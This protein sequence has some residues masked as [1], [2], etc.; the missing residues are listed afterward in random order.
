MCVRGM[1]ACVRVWLACACAWNVFVHIW[2]MCVRVGN[3]CMRVC[4]DVCV[5]VDAEFAGQRAKPSVCM[6]VCVCVRSCVD[7]RRDACLSP[8]TCFS[9][10]SY[11]QYKVK[12]PSARSDGRWPFLSVRW[13]GVFF[14][15][16]V[17]R[18]CYRVM[19]PLMSHL[20]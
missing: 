16:Q 1:C 18:R 11:H 7:S 6:C 9:T 12:S 20:L 3:L 14:T 2:V 13:D 8:S 4:D 10:P 19:F 17:V 5:C 15:Q